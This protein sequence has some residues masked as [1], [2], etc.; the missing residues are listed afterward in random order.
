MSPHTAFIPIAGIAMVFTI[1]CSGSNG[2]TETQKAGPFEVKPMAPQQHM[3]TLEDLP[4][5]FSTESARKGPKVVPRPP[6]ATLHVPPGFDVNVFAH[7]VENPRWMTLAPN[8]DVI[9]VESRKDRVKILRDEDADGTAEGIFVFAEGNRAGLDQPMGVQIKDGFLYIANTSGVVRFSYRAGQ[10][11]A[12]APGE[13]FITGITPGGYNQHWTRNILF[14]PDEGLLYLSVGSAS[15]VNAEDLPRASI[16]VYRA[17]GSNPETFG[18][19]LRNPV[20]MALNPVT[21]KLWTTVN[22]R[23]G[24]GDN[25]VPDYLTSVQ[26][27]G[28]YGWPYAYLSPMNEDPR[29]KGERNDLVKKTITP[30][31]LFESHSAALGLVFY[32]GSQFPE[33]YRNDAFVAFRGSWNRSQGTGYKVVRIPFNPDGTPKGGYEDFLWGWLIDPQG[34]TTWGRPV[35]LLVASDGSLLV[36]DEMGEIVWRVSYSD[37]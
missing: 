25:L 26:E 15:N 33:E 17:D 35:G 11:T 4:A 31:V 22:E 14:S 21:G 2:F 6:K 19:G 34:P 16:Q 27:G 29:R 8:G 10:T 20:G 7:Q 23:D 3:V 9:L 18:Y 5:P 1:S 37:Q 32:T 30:D 12:D 13:P 28:F 36:T 24:L